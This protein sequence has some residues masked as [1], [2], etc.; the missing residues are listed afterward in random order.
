MTLYS[1]ITQQTGWLNTSRPLKAEDLAGRIILLDFWT[2]CCI[3]CMH[4]IPDL[5]YLEEKFAADLTVIGVHSAKFANERDSENIRQAIL[6]YDIHH[7]VVNDFD[8]ST[9]ESFGIRAWPTFVLIGPKGNIEATYSGEGNRKK[10]EDDITRL[11]KKYAGKINREPLP[12]ALEKDKQPPSILSFPGKIA[13]GDDKLFVSDSAHQ[14]ILIMTPDGKITDT[15]GSGKPGAQDG[16]FDQ[17]SFNAPQGVLYKDGMLYIAD[18]NNHRLRA[19]DL[20]ART[21]TTLAG[22]GMQGYDRKVTPKP[23][24]EASLASPWDLAFYPDDTH[25]AIAMAGLHQLWSYDIEQKTIGVIAGSGRESIDDGALPDNSL[26]QPSG[27]SA[28]GGKLYFVD[29][30][31]SSLRVLENGEVKTLI[32]TGLFDFGYKEGARDMA[33]MQHPLGLLAADKEIF[34]ADSY[35]HSIRRFDPATGLLSNF[36]GHGE[37]GAEDG[38]LAQAEFNEPNAIARIGEKLYVADTNNNALRVIDLAA[39]TVST[40]AVTETRPVSVEY[41][42]SLPN[43]AKMDAVALQAGSPIPLR[44]SLK[45]GWHINKDA[46]S[47]LA[48]FDGAKKPVA[49]FE[50]DAITAGQLTLPALPVGDY[51]LQ[52]TLFYCE[53]KEGAQCLIKS[54][55]VPVARANNGQAELVLEV[56]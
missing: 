25:I 35:N 40:L 47:V 24:L 38:A 5:H 48:I 31:T 9:W 22:T 26:S 55:D 34:I 39:K 13:I 30:E 28:V 21:V 44:I 53:D 29:A 19:A 10:L 2:Y 12:L 32:G 49:S 18:T 15:I 23:A 16:A 6:R 20:K 45:E 33:L 1:K 51:R 37:R 42:D 7:P 27:L 17:A 54:F 41:S 56:N 3:N 36:A 43:L 52:A 8:F 4:V 14:R 11:Q 50:R 46:P